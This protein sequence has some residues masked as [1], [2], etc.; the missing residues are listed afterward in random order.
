[1]PEIFRNNPED[2]MP[3]STGAHR[4]VEVQ[5]LSGQEPSAAGR[6]LVDTFMQKMSEKYPDKEYLKIEEDPAVG[7]KIISYVARSSDGELAG[8]ISGENEG[9]RQF[10]AFW[11]MTD[12]EYQ[13]SKPAEKLWEKV[14]SDFDKVKLYAK[15]FG[16]DKNV[17]EQEEL[18]RQKA[19]V[20]YYQRLGFK[21]DFGPDSYAASNGSMS[22]VWERGKKKKNK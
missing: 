7:R 13:D 2:N 15:V 9:D 3:L 5:K 21:Q 19:L 8:L 11:F 4:D 12:P 17:T 22:M 10:K 18:S 6:M 14:F 16:V 20:R 1:M